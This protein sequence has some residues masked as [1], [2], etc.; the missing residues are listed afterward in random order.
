[1]KKFLSV[2]WSEESFDLRLYHQLE[3]RYKGDVNAERVMRLRRI[4]CPNRSLLALVLDAQMHSSVFANLCLVV[5]QGKGQRV[6][7]NQLSVPTLETLLILVW[8]FPES[9]RV[10]PVVFPIFLEG[11]PIA[12]VP[13]GAD[14]FLLC[15]P[16]AHLLRRS[17][18]R[19]LALRG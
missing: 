16:P 3:A 9:C 14:G 1:M 4:S 5:N 12:L 15:T 13:Q 6:S 10:Q 17:G 18:P 8:E 2:L 11:N 7:I 19:V